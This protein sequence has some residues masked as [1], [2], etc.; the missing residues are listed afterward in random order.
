MA[1]TP[2]TQAKAKGDDKSIPEVVKELW[3][4]L[5]SYGKQ[6]TI[7]P[8]KQLGRFVGFG[9]PAMYL[10]GIGIVLLLIG[11]LRVLQMETGPHLTGNWSWVPY[12]ATLGA[13]LLFAGLAVLAMFRY[14]S[15]QRK[16]KQ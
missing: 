1:A 12:V 11:L 16:A 5:V 3:E 8:L 15:K 4:L 6:E 9:L 13:A 14:G 7:D 10:L 2:P